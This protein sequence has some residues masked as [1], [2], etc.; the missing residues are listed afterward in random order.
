MCVCVLNMCNRIDTA[1]KLKRFTC[2]EEAVCAD[3]HLL[4]AVLSVGSNTSTPYQQ[5]GPESR[6][7][8]NTLPG[9][10]LTP[11]GSL[12]LAGL[13][14]DACVHVGQAGAVHQQKLPFVGKT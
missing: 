3:L 13:V 11:V 1:D 7:L 4:P 9:G 10:G 12:L 14:S 5:I 2:C 8:T 6:Q